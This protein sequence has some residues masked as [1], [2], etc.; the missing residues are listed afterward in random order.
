MKPALFATP[1]PARGER[2]IPPHAIRAVTRNLPNP[3]PYIFLPTCGQ[4]Q[5]ST[6][7]HHN[8]YYHQLLIS[9]IYLSVM[10]GDGTRHHLSIMGTTPLTQETVGYARRKVILPHP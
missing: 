9:N 7:P 1:L 2:T 4:K 5:L 8:H 3:H 10:Y 6:Y